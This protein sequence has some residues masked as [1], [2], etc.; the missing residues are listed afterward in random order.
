[1]ERGS[2]TWRSHWGALSHLSRYILLGFVLITAF[3]VITMIVHPMGGFDWGDAFVLI[4]TF[5]QSFVVL[6]VVFGIF[7]RSDL[8]FDAVV[9]FFAVGFCICIPVG[10]VLEGIL[11]NVF[12]GLLYLAYWLLQ[13]I[14]QDDAVYDFLHE[15]QSVL[16][17][18]GELLNAF[19]VAALVEELC[20]YFGFRALE[21]PDLL[22]ITGLDR[23]AEQAKASGDIDSYKF[24]SQLVSEF[25]RSQSDLS[26]VDSRRGRRKRRM[27]RSSHDEDEDEPELRTTQQQAAAITTGMISVAVGLACAENLM[28]VLFLGGTGDFAV[29]D[30]LVILLFRSIFPIHA[31]SAAMQSINMIRK[32]IEDK[33]EYGRRNIGI[34]KIIFPAVLLHGTFD[35]ILLCANAYVGSQ[36]NDY[37]ESGEY[38]GDDHEPYNVLAVNLIT[39]G[40]IIGV[41][42][43]GFS[44]YSHQNKLQML[45]LAKLSVDD[46]SSP[47]EV[48]E[49]V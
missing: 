25:P 2:G 35:A 28:Y 41:M 4:A 43:L 1:M 31:L 21:H 18:F 24:E 38:Y 33:E 44:W 3:V 9:K 20:K 42:V 49:I 6:F 14:F 48:P 26:S 40:G 32:F 5:T 23:T 34:G 27:L 30:E 12:F 8:S 16:W 37:Y 45:R 39:A 29:A 15:H 46:V 36:W 10:F 19:F 13:A 47:Y 22:F 17:I 11:V 7:H